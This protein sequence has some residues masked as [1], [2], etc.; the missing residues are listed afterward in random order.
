M[1]LT[2]YHGANLIPEG[3]ELGE[4][5]VI[6]KISVPELE[7]VCCVA[8]T[9]DII[10]GNG[11]VAPAI[12]VPQ[13]GFIY[14]GIPTAVTFIICRYEK[15]PLLLAFINA[16]G[17]GDK[18]IDVFSVPRLAVDSALPE[19]DPSVYPFTVLGNNAIGGIFNEPAI[20][21]TL[22]GTPSQI[23]GYTPKNR[24]A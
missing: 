19:D 11:A 22:T 21:K 13:N 16:D 4:M 7:A 18:I 23:D 14:N 20:N 2:T 1:Y 8:F 9:G 17:N 5:K 3:L 15:L 6:E 10:S 12:S 24:K